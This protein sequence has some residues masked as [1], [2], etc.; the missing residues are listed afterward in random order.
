[1]LKVAKK[2]V[3]TNESGE[4]TPLTPTKKLNGRLG[5]PISTDHDVIIQNGGLQLTKFNSCG[6]YRNS[7]GGRLSE[8]FHCKHDLGFSVTEEDEPDSN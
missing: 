1:M 4:E 6:R 7:T 8:S 3:D 5:K 2:V